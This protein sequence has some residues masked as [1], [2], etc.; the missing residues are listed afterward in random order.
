M[1]RLADHAGA[2]AG[3]PSHYPGLPGTANWDRTHRNCGWA[4]RLCESASGAFPSSTARDLDLTRHFMA[5][6]GARS[7]IP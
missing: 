6:H 5:N 2:P 7:P 1:G 4:C 3:L